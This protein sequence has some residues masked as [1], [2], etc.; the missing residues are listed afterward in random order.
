MFTSPHP[1][2]GVLEGQPTLRLGVVPH[3][4]RGPRAG[5]I[6]WGAL[7]TSHC[8]LGVQ[9]NLPAGDREGWKV[10][11]PREANLSSGP[12]AGPEGRVDRTHSLRP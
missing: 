5:H 9:D 6:H 1:G 2:P 11:S 10:L 4:P 3:S 12:E 8:H 7:L